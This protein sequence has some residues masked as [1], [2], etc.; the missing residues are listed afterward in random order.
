LTFDSAVEVAT[1]A[2][3]HQVGD[4]HRWFER[5]AQVH[6]ALA[7][8]SVSKVSIDSAVREVDPAIVDL[9]QACDLCRGEIQYRQMD[10]LLSQAFKLRKQLTST[11]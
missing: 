4:A 10:L 2:I 8:R 7:Q 1:S 3:D 9:Q 11:T 5:R 6:I